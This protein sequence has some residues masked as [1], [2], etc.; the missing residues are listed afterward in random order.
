MARAYDDDLRRKYLEAYDRGEGTLKALALRFG[1]SCGWGWKVS[2]ARKRSGQM[3]RAS[4]HGGRPSRVTAE[5]RKQIQDW[6]GLQPD[7]TLAEL[8]RRLQHQVNMK[9][10]V[11]RLW[12]LMRQLGLDLKRR[13]STFRHAIRKPTGRDVSGC[14]G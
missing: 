7:M 9:L 11:G 10:S 6:F 13:H 1:V 8:Q 4:G 14:R 5:V 3:E 12:Q 2:A